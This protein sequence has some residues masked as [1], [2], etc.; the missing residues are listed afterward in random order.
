MATSSAWKIDRRADCRSRRHRAGG[1]VR[2]RSRRAPA[3]RRASRARPMAAPAPRRSGAA[4][5]GPAA[6]QRCT[7]YPYNLGTRSGAA[8]VAGGRERC[9]V[10]GTGRA[11][12]VSRL[13]ERKE[14]TMTLS[15]TT[16][17][18]LAQERAAYN[19]ELFHG[20]GRG[21]H[22]A[23]RLFEASSYTELLAVE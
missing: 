22:L 11:A 9:P 23:E 3:P 6:T 21:T 12:P 10:R 19:Q 5:T 13:T 16:L 15:R 20:S 18:R 1:H 17:A 4:A 14:T 7:Y 2:R 8:A